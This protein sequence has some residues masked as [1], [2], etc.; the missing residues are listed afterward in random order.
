MRIGLL[1]SICMAVVLLL[2]EGAGSFMSGVSG[3]HGNQSVDLAA[4]STGASQ[5]FLEA[6]DEHPHSSH[7]HDASHAPDQCAGA[8]C[9]SSTA[10]D[11]ASACVIRPTLAARFPVAEHFLY[12]GGSPFSLLRPPRAIA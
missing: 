2:G 11:N 6:S 12:I 10:A 3:H 4:A 9:C 5:L 7:C 8:Q 1:L